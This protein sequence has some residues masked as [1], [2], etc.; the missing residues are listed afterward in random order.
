MQEGYAERVAGA[1]WGR[2]EVSDQM[3]PNQTCSL[4]GR[5]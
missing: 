4:L 1:R 3:G 2:A 5:A